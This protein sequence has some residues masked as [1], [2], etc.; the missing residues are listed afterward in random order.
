VLFPACAELAPT[1]AATDPLLGAEAPLTG[2]V[3]LVDDDPAILETT[4]TALQSMGLQVLTAAD[5]L[6]ALALFAARSQE[7]DLVFM[8][9]TMPRMDGEKAFQAMR[10]LDPKVP[11][12]LSSGYSEAPTTTG[13]MSLG[14]AGFIHKPYTL[15]AL[16]Q[17]IR[18]ALGERR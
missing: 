15:N 3:L 1:A 7:I 8:D 12:I 11:V 14:L 10:R 9:L 4:A 13:L 6:E 2:S 17:G 18:S 16:R 5:G